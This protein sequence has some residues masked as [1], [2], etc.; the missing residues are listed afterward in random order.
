MIMIWF[1]VLPL[2]TLLRLVAPGRADRSLLA[3]LL[4][5]HG[6]I[7]LTAAACIALLNLLLEIF[8]LGNNFRLRSTIYVRALGVG[9]I[10]MMMTMAH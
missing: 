9:G 5:R 8:N 7:C 10:L 3:D 6:A 4:I 1:A 2:A